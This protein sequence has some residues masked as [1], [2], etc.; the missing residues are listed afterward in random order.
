MRV[1]PSFQSFVRVL[2]HDD[3][4]VDHGADGDGDAA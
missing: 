1:A 4:G 3:G 2:D